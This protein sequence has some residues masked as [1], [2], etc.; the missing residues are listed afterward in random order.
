[1]I[2]RPRV[3][4]VLLVRGSAERGVHG[5]HH[6]GGRLWPDPAGAAEGP[7]RAEGL[8]PE[9]QAFRAQNLRQQPRA[10]FRLCR[11]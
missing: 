1:M 9:P 11:A 5:R 4:R 7:A 8:G 10:S 2:Q 3:A 6:Q